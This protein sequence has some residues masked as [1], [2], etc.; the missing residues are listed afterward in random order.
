MTRV[1]TLVACGPF[2]AKFTSQGSDL[3]VMQ[4]V[5]LVRAV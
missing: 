3:R 5:H 4:E 2:R 1:A